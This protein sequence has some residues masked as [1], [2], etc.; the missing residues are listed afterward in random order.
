MKKSISAPLLSQIKS[1]QFIG[2]GLSGWCTLYSIAVITWGASSTLVG[3]TQ[4]GCFAMSMTLAGIEARRYQSGRA[5]PPDPLQWVTGTSAS[6]INHNLAQVMQQRGFWTEPCKSVETD[7][8][9]GVRAVNAGRTLVFETARWQE[10]IIDLP[11]AQ[12]TDENRKKVG[13]D[14]AFIVG[15]GK[16]DQDAQ[17]YVKAHA[18]RLLIGE[19]LNEIINAEK[20]VMTVVKEV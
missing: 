10:P 17:S 1:W 7:L 13:A 18:V 5:T 3:N 2:L 19:E 12:A 9:F 8:G 14:L 20:P 6:E 16:P 15:I 4:G 11:H